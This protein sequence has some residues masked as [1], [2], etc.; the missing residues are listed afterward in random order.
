M[1]RDYQLKAIRETY[2]YLR[3]HDGNPCIV[4]PTGSGKAHIIAGFC[5]DILK[6][7]PDAKILVLS[8]VKELLVQ[9]AEKI[10]LAW[11]EAPLG[12]YSA[13][14]GTKEISSITVAG[15]QSIWRKPEELGRID[16]VI[17][18]E[19]HM[20]QNE[21]EGMYRRLLSSLHELN[22]K[23]RM[24]GL[25]A[26]PYRLGQGLLTE[27]D[28]AIF[29]TL[30]E[31]V[32]IEELVKRG[33]LARLTS[34]FTDLQMN[35]EG[36]KKVQGDYEK[37]ELES[38]VNSS[39]VNSK[40][41]A[42]TIRRAGNRRAWLVFCV[43]ISHAEKMRDEFI[44]QGVRAEAITSKTTPAERD[45]IFADFK[46]GKIRAVTN[47]G[48]ATTGFD[49]PDIDVIVMARPTLSPGLYIQMSGRG[50]RV[51][52]P[53]HHQDCLV[54][55]F[56]GNI[57]RHGAVTKIIPPRRTVK[58]GKKSQ[59][60]GDMFKICP[61]CK[62]TVMKRARECVH[63][64]HIF[65]GLSDLSVN[66]DIMEGVNQPE[67][68]GDDDTI[69]GFQRMKVASWFWKVIYRKKDSMPMIRVDFYGTDKLQG[70]KQLFLYIMQEGN[71][72]VNA[73]RQMKSL[74]QGVR[75]PELS[76]IDSARVL[77]ELCDAVRENFAPPLWIEYK[78]DLTPDGRIHFTISRWG[79][80]E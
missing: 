32:T 11:P 78:E 45:R 22:P 56:A 27:G 39:D 34:T 79:W 46:A 13:G 19:A 41:V 65:S 60:L 26:T 61:K 37:Q 1:L 73:Y 15:I 33:F 9:D 68:P 35:V 76:K 51:K 10:R 47:V 74:L 25:T 7:K 72:R 71:A 5:E 18:D 28:D 8:H 2:K 80:D 66:D 29:Q 49:Y 4:A 57:A 24:I 14:L 40:V 70:P 52:S 67:L 20:I 58:T 42:E 59:E 63:C 38:R 44:A 50:M 43:S 30:I 12:I 23:M 36:I 17:V 16:V 31:C 48:V 21:D 69:P 53:G 64:G 6:R 77:H 54:L 55:D 62:N 75:L 3:E